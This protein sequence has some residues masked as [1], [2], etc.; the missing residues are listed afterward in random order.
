MIASE[1]DGQFELDVKKPRPIR[2]QQHPLGLRILEAVGVAGNVPDL[3]RD[4]ARLHRLGLVVQT[5][6]GELE[7]SGVVGRHLGLRLDQL[8]RGM[9]KRISIRI[10]NLSTISQVPRSNE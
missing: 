5:A 4:E 8:V 10:Y 1:S 6:D 3:E 2:L 9:V 7:P